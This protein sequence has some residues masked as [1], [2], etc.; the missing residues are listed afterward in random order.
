MKTLI[1]S[2]LLSALSSIA[3][4]ADIP[5]IIG[6]PY[7]K[8]KQALAVAGLTPLNQDEVAKVTTEPLDGTDF[9]ITEQRQQ[10]RPEVEACGGIGFCNY[11]HKN[12]AGEVYSVSVYIPEG[13]GA[14]RVEHLEK[15]AY[16]LELPDGNGAHKADPTTVALNDL[17][18]R[19]AADQCDE[20]CV[21]N[22]LV[23]LVPKKL[24]K[25]Q[26]TE[27]A[28][29]GKSIPDYRNL[30]IAELMAAT[31]QRAMG[32]VT[33]ASPEYNFQN[34]AVSKALYLASN[35]SARI[36]FEAKTGLTCTLIFMDN[37]GYMLKIDMTGT[38][39]GTMRSS[40]VWLANA[41]DDMKDISEEPQRFNVQMMRDQKLAKD[42]PK[43]FRSVMKRRYDKTTEPQMS[44]V[45]GLELNT[46]DSGVCD[47]L[48]GRAY[49]FVG[50]ASPEPAKERSID[51]TILIL[52]RSGCFIKSM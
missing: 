50:S 18:I 37:Q 7:D 39:L 36:C 35:K 6:Q 45:Q 52:N 14:D 34:A 16:Q 9:R 13:G 43:I 17:Q 8:A 25:I 11:L 28:L 51:E 20:T 2:L 42:D 24:P 4:A 41:D 10:G 48:I 15:T 46:K 29:T 1:T 5:N 47:R 26:S 31:Q 40:A 33:L 12:K 19:I 38:D 3:Y 27:D 32:T 23:K 30:N 21:Q 49:L 22:E 44:V